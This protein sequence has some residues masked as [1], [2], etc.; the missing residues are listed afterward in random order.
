MLRYKLNQNI[1]KANMEA[2]KCGGGVNDFMLDKI[3][4]KCA[5]FLIKSK[6]TTTVKA[7]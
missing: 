4:K 7:K 1:G 3:D 6:T 5:K 2:R